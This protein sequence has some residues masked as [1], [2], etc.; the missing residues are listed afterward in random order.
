MSD[1]YEGEVGSRRTIIYALDFMMPANFYQGINESAIIRE[2]VNNIHV[3]TLIDSDG[4]G[5]AS[6]PDVKLTV[7]PNPLNVSPDS[8]YGFT[9]TIL[10]SESGDS[11]G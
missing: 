4:F 2:V 6:V 8:D 9:T 10:R 11:S 7:L 5:T 3:D 1:D